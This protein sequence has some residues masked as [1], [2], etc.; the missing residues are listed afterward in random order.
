MKPFTQIIILILLSFPLFADEIPENYFGKYGFKSCSWTERDKAG[1]FYCESYAINT[2][3]IEKREAN[4][5]S[6]YVHIKLAGDRGGGCTYAA[7][8]KM[9][10]GELVASGENTTTTEDDKFVD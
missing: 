4:S 3:A 7:T 5:Q 9:I 8:G 6:A 10:D 1:N 2:L